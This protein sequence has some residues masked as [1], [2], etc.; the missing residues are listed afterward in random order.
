MAMLP[1][2][3]NKS[4]R[5]PPGFG[6]SPQPDLTPLP[7]PAQGSSILLVNPRTGEQQQIPLDGTPQTSALINHYMTQGFVQEGPGAPPLGRPE[8]P[9][10]PPPVIAP[11]PMG[12]EDLGPDMPSL[13]IE[14]MPS[15]VPPT[16]LGWPEVPQR[17]PRVTPPPVQDEAPWMQGGATTRVI[18]DLPGPPETNP[19]TPP[20]NELRFTEA[21]WGQLTPEQRSAVLGDPRGY[22]VSYP[23]GRSMHGSGPLRNAPVRPSDYYQGPVPE[24]GEPYFRPP[25][26][27][28]RPSMFPVQGPIEALNLSEPVVTSTPS[29]AAGEQAAP[30][31][32][33]LLDPRRPP[34]R[35]P[36]GMRYPGDPAPLPPQLPPPPVIAPPPPQDLLDPRRPPGRLPAGQSYAD[37]DP[38]VIN[39]TPPTVP[40]AP[41]TP[42]PD[43]TLPLTPPPAAGRSMPPGF[44][45]TGRPS[46]TLVNPDTGDQQVITLDGTPQTSGFINDLFQ[47]GYV[48]RD[49]PEPPTPPVVPPPDPT[50]PVVTPPPGGAGQGGSITLVN[51]T[52]GEERTIVLDGTSETSA[53][54]NDLMQNQGFEPPAPPPTTV[55]PTTVDA[56]TGGGYGD[57]GT[58]ET[59]QIPAID[60]PPIERI[61][62]RF[63]QDFD[64]WYSDVIDAQAGNLARYY[65]F[66]IAQTGAAMIP[67]GMVP[68]PRAQT[69]QQFEAL[70]FLLSGQGYDPATLAR[71][72]ATATDAAAMAGR[73][74]AGTARLMG[75]QSGLAGSPAALAMEA[76]ARR[77]QGGAT[78]RA[79][80]QIE[81]ANAMQGMQNRA[82]GSQMELNR[83][84][85]G[86]AQA[87]QMA[88]NNASNILG[89]MKTNVGNLQH[90]SLFNVGNRIGQ[91]MTQAGAQ[92]GL[93][94]QGAQAYNQAALKRAGE[95][96]LF[97]PTAQMTR[98]FRQAQL[99]REKDLADAGFSFTRFSDA[100]NRLGGL[101]GGGAGGDFYGTGTNLYQWGQPGSAWAGLNWF[102]PRS[103][104]SGG[105]G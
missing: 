57:F 101:A 92:T 59:P 28:I 5:M 73:S 91:Q 100:Q 13:P 24:F 67:L 66:P 51:P 31:P 16:L 21:E 52:T 99:K 29:W 49:A 12:P 70:R 81:I 10:R 63:G 87:N 30:P 27:A 26:A 50:P 36:T 88:L 33:N 8:V 42:P 90:S 22:E 79:L 41:V 3:S 105:A 7:A 102:S 14:P 71:M 65:D 1:P 60:L 75:Q 89:A 97:N 68:Q 15:G 104:A 80:N 62:P 86:A 4:P 61:D 84:V 11:P 82:A 96:T 77:M 72:R 56:T 23:D 37:I 95:S 25:A 83:Q 69:P 17:P 94:G 44:G 76:A 47:Q 6:E 39:P 34:G 32:Q 46:L 38:P 48:N 85:S 20:T 78:T 54:L 19:F 45:T 18:P 2:E 40:V 74:G 43:V 35:L 93:Y 98:D 103:G 58:Y 64:Q 55:D 9:Q 53:L